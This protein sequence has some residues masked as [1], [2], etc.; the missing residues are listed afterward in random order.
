[1][2]FILPLD[3]DLITFAAVAL[4]AA[5][6]R[7]AAGGPAVAS[8]QRHGAPSAGSVVLLVARDGE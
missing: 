6:P 5:V 7:R 8:A 2:Q 3:N 4:R 1:M